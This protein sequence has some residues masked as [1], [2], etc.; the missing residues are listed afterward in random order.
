MSCLKI[1]GKI[2][3]LVLLSTFFMAL[4]G[5]V[6]Y[7]YTKVLSNDLEQMYQ[8]NLLSVKRINETRHNFRAVQVMF[9]QL[10]STTQE[11]AKEQALLQQIKE[12]SQETNETIQA[13]EKQGLSPQEAQI[14]TQ[15]KDTIALYRSEREKALKL[16]QAGQKAA[17]FQYFLQYAAPQIDSINIK[18]KELA[19]DCKMKLNTWEKSPQWRYLIW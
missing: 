7:Y 2:I 6:G 16:D 11:P 4:A 13:Y 15:L 12:L 3:A 17:A 8:D 19:A 10:L 18:L 1:K 5:S 14:L 9:L